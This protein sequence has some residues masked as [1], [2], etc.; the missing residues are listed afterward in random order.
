MGKENVNIVGIEPVGSY[1]V[2]LRFDD[3]HETG[4]YSWDTLYR[5][6][7][8]YNEYW[9][10]YLRRLKEAGHK[11]KEPGPYVPPLNVD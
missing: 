4:I 6:G 11:R 1:A 2:L 3:G 8:N 10:D 7:A 9:Q 5:L